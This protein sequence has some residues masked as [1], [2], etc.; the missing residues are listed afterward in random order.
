MDSVKRLLNEHIAIIFADYGLVITCL[1]IGFTIG[2]LFKTFIVDRRTDQ[3]INDRIRD[4]DL[5]INDLKQIVYERLN[6]EI[7]QIDP[8]LFKR[9]KKFFKKSVKGLKIKNS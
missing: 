8:G 4:K 3:L 2:W 1:F 7:H 9:L 6:V 5:Q